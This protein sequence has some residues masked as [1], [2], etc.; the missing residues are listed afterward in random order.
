M[1]GGAPWQF[2]MWLWAVVSIHTASLLVES[3]E[4]RLESLESWNLFGIFGIF[5]I[6]GIF[7]IFGIFSNEIILRIRQFQKISRKHNLILERMKR[8]VDSC[9]TALRQDA[10]KSVDLGVI[11]GF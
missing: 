11:V 5:G 6:L 8:I 4:S 10:Q 3:W 1:F 9:S 2:E 7:G